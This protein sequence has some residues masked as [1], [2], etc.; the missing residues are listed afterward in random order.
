MGHRAEVEGAHQFGLVLWWGGFQELHGL[1]GLHPELRCRSKPVL[2]DEDLPQC[3]FILRRHT[4][5][6]DGVAAIRRLQCR[7]H[8]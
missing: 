6:A 1:F 2:V 4:D 8:R 7:L 5:S 3:P